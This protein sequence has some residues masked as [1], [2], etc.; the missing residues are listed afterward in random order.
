MLGPEARAV[1]AGLFLRLQERGGIL[2]VR[3]HGVHQSPAITYHP[4]VHQC[5][6]GPHVCQLAT[7][8]IRPGRVRLQP[9]LGTEW[10]QPEEGLSSL[11]AEWALLRL[12]A[13]HA[14]EPNTAPVGTSDAVTIGHAAHHTARS[15][16]AL[17]LLG[18]AARRYSTQGDQEPGCCR[19]RHQ[20]PIRSGSQ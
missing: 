5:G 13:V 18:A 20:I 12:G 11:P 17:G 16:P 2:D 3:W 6:V 14:Y 19:S 15:Q 1:R 8:P 7:V 9:N 4:L 10:K